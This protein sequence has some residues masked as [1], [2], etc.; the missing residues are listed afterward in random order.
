MRESLRGGCRPA[1]A[2]QGTPGNNCSLESSKFSTV[3]RALWPRKTAAHLAVRA[4][5]SERAAKYWLK[6]VRRGGR[7]PSTAALLAV[8]LEIEDD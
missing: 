8:L 1:T 7:K 6:G 3:A 5:V 2:N 4:G